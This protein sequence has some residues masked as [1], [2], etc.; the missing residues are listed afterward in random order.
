MGGERRRHG[1]LGRRKEW[2]W[3]LGKEEMHRER[4]GH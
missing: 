4:A 2:A 3:S 1:L